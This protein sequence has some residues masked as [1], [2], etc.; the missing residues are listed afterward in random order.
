MKI[1]VLH[2]DD[3]IKSTERLKTFREV[4]ENRGWEYQRVSDSSANIVEVLS[5]QSLFVGDKLVV[6]DDTKLVSTSVAKWIEKN[7]KN[8]TTTLVI[9]SDKKLPSTLIKLL[10]KDTKIEESKLPT[11]LW[12]LLDSFYP[13]N[14]KIFIKLLHEVVATEPIELIFSLLSKQLRDIYWVTIDESSFPQKG[15]RTNKLKSIGKFFSIKSLKEII[16]EFAEIDIKSKT[17]DSNLLDLL[18]FIA[19]SKLK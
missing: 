10:P 8:Y 12:T 11:K 4:A 9:Y 7:Q 17:S 19:I 3:Y 13:G 15:W 1:I 6:I 5:G 2:G 16:G 18:D 14:V